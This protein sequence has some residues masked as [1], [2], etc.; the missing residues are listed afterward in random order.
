MK[1]GIEDVKK[2]LSTVIDPDLKKDL[3]TLNMVK[4]IEVFSDAVKFTVVLT[5]PACP[6]KEVIRKDC[7]RAINEHLS[8][9]IRAEI[10][11]TSNVTTTRDKGPLLPDVKNII[12]IASGKGGVGKSTVAANLAV[13][14]AQ[15][16]ASVGL[17]DA[18]IYGPSVPVMF[19]CE[20]EQPGVQPVNG[21]NMIMPLEQYGVKLISIGF[22][23]PA[24][25]A[26]VW[27]GPMASS[28]LKQFISDTLWGPLDYL[29]I[30]L[31]PGTSD[32]HLTMVQTVPVT[33]AI[34][35]TTPQKVA[36]AD[37]RK[38]LQMFRQPQIN[39]PV[40]GIVEN[41]AYFTPPEL[42]DKKYYIFGESG[43]E[44]LSKQYDVPLL[45]QLPIEQEVRESGDSGYPIALK[46]TVSSEAFRNLAESLAQQVAIRNATQDKTKPVEVQ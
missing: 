2:A 46:N 43:G 26:V 44:N 25:N 11:M 39:V 12:A 37:A 1:Y 19:N 30:D 45:G 6:L 16:G 18:D 33:G 3:V 36:L 10:L 40:L 31:P 32:I 15:Q 21:K 7:E 35:V 5:T 38:G 8:P 17:I 42:P 14:L 13:S 9:E 29:L 27:R 28:A 24:D 23:T 20:H 4:D 41:M 22:L 34:I